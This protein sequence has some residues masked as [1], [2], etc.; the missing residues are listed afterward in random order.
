[1]SHRFT[2][3]RRLQ[4]RVRKGLTI[5]ALAIGVVVVS[6]TAGSSS[7]PP[8]MYNPP[9]GMVPPDA[10][11]RLIG[12][13]GEVHTYAVEEARASTVLRDGK[14]WVNI[15]YKGGAFIISDP[16]GSGAAVVRAVPP[17]AKLPTE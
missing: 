6:A 17:K 4:N 1:M 9:I 11:I 16:N 7:N 14:P 2:R 15:A 12:P 13:H 8:I 10:F 5:A 3:L